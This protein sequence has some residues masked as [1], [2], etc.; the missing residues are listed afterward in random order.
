MS[1][2]RTAT[3]SF[4]EVEAD[5]D[6]IRVVAGPDEGASHDVDT[7]LTRVGTAKGADLR[8]S[9]RGVSRLHCAL[10]VADGKI[11]LEDLGSK[12]GTY[13]NGE[14]LQQP[15]LLTNGDEI[16]I[17]RSVARFRFLVEGEPTQT[18]HTVS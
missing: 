4:H 1:D 3:Y 11:R 14:R 2:E 6:V 5:L 15:T 10:S 9:D 12:N 16:W 8:L 7:G 13:L 18:E 17:G